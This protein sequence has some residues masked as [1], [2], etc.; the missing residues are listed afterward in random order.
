MQE[1][2]RPAEKSANDAIISKKTGRKIQRDGAI[3]P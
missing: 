3:R 2:V 1:V